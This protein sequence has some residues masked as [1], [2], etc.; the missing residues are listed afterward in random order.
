MSGEQKPSVGVR[1][2]SPLEFILGFAGW[3]ALHILIARRLSE[4]VTY[5]LLEKKQAVTDQM[6]FIL[7]VAIPLG[8]LIGL[9]LLFLVRRSVAIGAIAALGVTILIA[10]LLTALKALFSVIY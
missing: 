5:M 9:I 7:F 3:F 10:V 8:N 1:V 2:V 4:W 6:G